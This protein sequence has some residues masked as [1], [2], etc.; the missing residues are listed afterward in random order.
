MWL[1]LTGIW[2][3]LGIINSFWQLKLLYDVSHEINQRLWRPD[4]SLLGVLANIVGEWQGTDPEAGG[5]SLVSG[6]VDYF[7]TGDDGGDLWPGVF[8]RN[9]PCQRD[10]V[11]VEKFLMESGKNSGGPYEILLRGVDERRRAEVGPHWE[12][13]AGFKPNNSDYWVAKLAE[14][15]GFFTCKDDLIS[16][17]LVCFLNLRLVHYS[18]CVVR[19][20]R[21]FSGDNLC[22]LTA[23]IDIVAAFWLLTLEDYVP[24]HGYYK[25]G[26]DLEA[27]VRKQRS[28]RDSFGVDRRE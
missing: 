23:E 15:G 10:F 6:L 22:F 12:H 16:A 3:S 28:F 24:T 7:C 17:E 11:G 21:C 20:P 2:V 9:V 18:G 14:L 1:V 4:Q 13:R 19:C 5:H 25:A 8:A 27:E 26:A